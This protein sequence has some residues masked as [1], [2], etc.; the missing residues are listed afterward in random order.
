MKKLESSPKRGKLGRKKSSVRMV[1]LVGRLRYRHILLKKSCK[2]LPFRNFNAEI[3][4]F[5]QTPKSPLNGSKRG[6][7]PSSAGQNGALFLHVKR[8]V[9]Q[10]GNN[11]IP[12]LNCWQSQYTPQFRKIKRKFAV[13][14]WKKFSFH[15]SM[16]PW[17]KGLMIPS[18][19]QSHRK[20][21]WGSLWGESRYYIR[22]KFP[23]M[24][25]AERFPPCNGGTGDVNWWDSV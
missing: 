11:R 13:F 24:F 15:P 18:S 3:R 4:L 7:F 25:H 9:R 20:G 23:E 17:P 8:A 21:C 22:L 16:S 1:H 10:H 2:L 19:I 5:I 14:W 6:I 12:I